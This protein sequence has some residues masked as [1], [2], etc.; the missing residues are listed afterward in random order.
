MAK[1]QGGLTT[2]RWEVRAE[3][4]IYAGGLQSL[5]SR[6]DARE[7]PVGTWIQG[8]Q[9]LQGCPWP[10]ERQTSMSALEHVWQQAE[11]CFPSFVLRYLPLPAPGFCFADIAGH[12]RLA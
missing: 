5:R 8:L 6:P 10:H 3:I 12:F 2:D 1:G 9:C 4:P 11:V 7:Q